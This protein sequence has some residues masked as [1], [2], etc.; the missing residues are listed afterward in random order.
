MENKK[1][2]YIGGYWSTNIGNAFFNVGAK[3]VLGRVFGGDNVNM[4]SDQSAYTP[5]W[6]TKKGN[7]P[8]AVDYWKHI[9]TDYVALLGPML[10]ESFLPIWKGTLDALKSRGVR[11]VLLSSGMMKCNEKTVSEIKEYFKENPPFAV[12]TRDRATYDTYKDSVENIYDGIC[13][14]FFVPD[15]IKPFGN[16]L[17]PLM[18]LNFDKIDEPRIYVDKECKYDRQ[19]D[20]NGHNYKIKFKGLANVGLKTDRFTDALIYAQSPLPR[21]KRPDRIGEYNV[22]RPDHRFNPMFV[23][24]VYRYNNSFS[25]DIPHT[26]AAIYA[27]AEITLS[28][29]VH[30]C[31]LTLAYGN[32]AYLFARTGRSGLLDRVGAEGITEGPVKIDLGNLKREKESLINWLNGLDW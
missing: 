16:D 1:I 5:G 17:S 20:Y 32:S 28:D 21:S 24:K 19:F 9:N 18:A 29:R 3:Y 6:K 2:A 13:F 14:A 26:Y 8:Y 7:I 23:R 11:Y 25:S 22:I 30:A 12:T 15:E 4:V 31:A 10:S 27:N